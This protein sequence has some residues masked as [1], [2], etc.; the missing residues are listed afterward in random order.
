MKI[1]GSHLF[2]IIGF[3]LAIL[4][5]ARLMREKRSPGS[6]IAWLLAIIMIPQIG[7]P[8]YFLFG[9]RKIKRMIE[10]KDNLYPDKTNDHPEKEGYKSN[11]EKILIR[12]GAPPASKGNQIELLSEGGLAYSRLMELLENAEHSIDITTFILGHDKVGRAIIETLTKKAKQGLKIRLI[13]DSLGCLRTR[14]RFVD[15]L[16]EAGGKV[17]I[18]M[19]MLPFHRKWS[20]HLRNHRKI[21]IVDQ[22]FAIVGGMNLAIIY[23]GSDSD[24]SRWNDFGVLVKGPLVSDICQIFDADWDFATGGKYKMDK[25]SANSFIPYQKKEDGISVQVVASGPDVPTDSFSE[26]ILTAILEAKKRVWIITP[27]FIPDEPLLKS[28]SLLARWGKDIC[29]ITPKRSNHLLADLAR[30]SYLRT[31][32]EAGVNVFYFYA[33]MLHSKIILIDNSIAI[34]GSANMDMRSFYLNYE[35]ALFIYSTAQAYAIEKIIVEEILP[36]SQVM[37]HGQPS[38]KRGVREWMEDISRVFSPFL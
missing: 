3:L 15:P 12:S 27:Y 7:I 2:A 31:L 24:K 35:I 13:L 34:V 11:T 23:M 32:A 25:Q 19:P 20:A 38:L 30:G 1:I 36:K 26:A 9:G 29:I 33:G 5:I 6:T 18:F 14:G 16:R 21:I 37:R 17:G 10:K 4:L 28:L 22:D 8:F